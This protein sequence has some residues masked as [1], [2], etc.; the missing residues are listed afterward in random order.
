MERLVSC[1]CLIYRPP[2]DISR[3]MNVHQGSLPTLRPRSLLLGFCVDVPLFA[4]QAHQYGWPPAPSGPTCSTDAS[5]SRVIILLLNQEK[6]QFLLNWTCLNLPLFGLT[7]FTSSHM[8]ILISLSSEFPTQWLNLSLG[9]TAMTSYRVRT[10][11]LL[12]V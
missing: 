8:L 10:H 3:S 2:R 1:K 5:M 4:L 9:N 11:Y 12:K 6:T 7:V